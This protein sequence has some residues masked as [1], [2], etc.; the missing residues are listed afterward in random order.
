VLGQRY[1]DH[2]RAA[3]RSDP[4]PDEAGD[5]PASVDRDDRVV[6]PSRRK[7]LALLQRALTAALAALDDRA[8]LRLSCYYVQELTL[9]QIGRLTGEH[10][11]TV[12]RKLDKA[13]REIRQHVDGELQNGCGL[14]PDQVG[15]CYEYA[16]E[17]WPFDLTR[18]LTQQ[19]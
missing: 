5:L 10:E 18:A 1:V 11:A 3:R 15:L 2:V 13:R 7:Y 4:L 14:T 16:L 19:E 8:R 6:D 12:S 17:E 9:A